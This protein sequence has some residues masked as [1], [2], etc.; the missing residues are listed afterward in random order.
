MIQVIHM[1]FLYDKRKSKFNPTSISLKHRVTFSFSMFHVDNSLC[2][3]N[4]LSREA[5]PFRGFLVSSTGAGAL[6]CVPA[7]LLSIILSFSQGEDLR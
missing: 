1:A 3:S 4:E 6:S 7:L 5:A 2:D